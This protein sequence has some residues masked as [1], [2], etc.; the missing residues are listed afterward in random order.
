MVDCHR[1]SLSILRASRASKQFGAGQRRYYRNHHGSQRCGCSRRK[2]HRDERGH[3]HFSTC[4]L[5]QRRNIFLP[6][7]NPGQYTV[8]VEAAGFKK[9]VQSDVIVEVSKTGT[10]D[11]TLSTGAA[12]ETVQVTADQIALNT[13][14]PELGSTIEPVVVAALPV[15]VSGRGRQIDQLQFLAP[16]T[17]GRHVLSSR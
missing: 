17:T 9:G 4:G 8:T 3:L 5:E 1:I 2:G 13:T 10:I 7:L 12:T 11:F 15:Q 16:G 14:A 6:R